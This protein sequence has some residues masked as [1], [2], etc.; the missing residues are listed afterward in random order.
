MTNQQLQNIKA[1]LTEAAGHIDCEGKTAD[2][3]RRLNEAAAGIQ[4]E[5]HAPNVLPIV[6]ALERIR[7]AANE[8]E[9]EEAAD[10]ICNTIIS[11]SAYSMTSYLTAVRVID[12]VVRDRKRAMKFLPELLEA[13]GIKPE[14]ANGSRTYTYMSDIPRTDLQPMECCVSDDPKSIIRYTA[15]YRN[16][17]DTFLKFYHSKQDALKWI[18]SEI[19]EFSIKN[20]PKI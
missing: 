8:I 2:L 10:E 1:L 19:G 14:Y 6:Q 7:D 5:D 4:A 15:A 9:A 11:N 16:Y 13:L 12:G 3:W 17:D 20:F 18:Y